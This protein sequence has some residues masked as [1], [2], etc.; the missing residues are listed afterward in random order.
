MH[1]K[2][3]MNCSWLNGLRKRLWIVTSLLSITCAVD[4]YRMVVRILMLVYIYAK[5]NWPLIN[6]CMCIVDYVH[7][8]M[9]ALFFYFTLQCW[10][11][12]EIM[13]QH[14]LC[15]KSHDQREEDSCQRK[16]KLDILI[17][18]NIWDVLYI[19]IA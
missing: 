2:K 4:V 15:Y 11:W 1:L 7:V 8:Y 19:E 10:E 18:N 3:S 14:N 13:P 5:F 17:F 6:Q 16:S 12:D 9:H